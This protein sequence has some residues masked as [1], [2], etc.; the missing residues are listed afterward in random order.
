VGQLSKPDKKLLVLTKSKALFQNPTF[1]LLVVG[2]SL[3]IP[4]SHFSS[5][6][7]LLVSTTLLGASPIFLF[8]SFPL[9]AKRFSH[10]IHT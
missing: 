5:L 8:A 4:L 3:I 9:K 1:Q 2:A 7:R 6:F 10:P